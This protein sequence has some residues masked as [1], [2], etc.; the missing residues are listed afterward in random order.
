MQCTHT[1]WLSNDEFLSQFNE[2]IIRDRVPV[3]GSIDITYLCNLNCLHCYVGPQSFRRSR[4]Q[5]EL[6]TDT[7]LSLIDEIAE[8][9]C[10]NVLLTGGEPIFR[11]DFPTLYRHAKNNG[12]L[13][14][15]FSNGTL[16]TETIADLFEDLPPQAVEITLYG[17]TAAT[18][19]RITGIKGSYRKCLN[20]IEILLGRGIEVKLKTILM[21]LNRHEFLDMENMAKGFGVNFRF[22]GAIF[23]RFN[24]DKFPLSLRIS[25]EEI[26]KKEFYDTARLNQCTK[27]YS[28]VKKRPVPDSLYNCGAGIGS[29]HIDAYG[30]LTPCLM[31]KGIKY[32]LLHGSFLEGWRD[33]MPLV[34]QK[35]VDYSYQ[36]TTC[37]K[38]VLC[39]YCPPFFEMENGSE[40]LRSEYLCSIGKKRFKM[41]ECSL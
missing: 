23:P 24:G 21:S 37:E 6:D 35:K 38:K 33:S 26:V 29:F 4:S 7:I 28:D 36:C 25:P 2:K 22:D 3:T 41:V 13:V 18:Y 16:I 5:N 30:N 20:G 17:A 32:N 8:A 11:K 10:L 34:R 31:T 40:Y 39:G 9:G 27:F 15:L 19:E 12:I 1:T 14:T